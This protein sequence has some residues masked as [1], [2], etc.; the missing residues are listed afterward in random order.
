[1]EAHNRASIEAECDLEGDGG[2]IVDDDDDDIND[3]D[4][5]NNDDADSS[6]DDKAGGKKKNVPIH[7]RH[8]TNIAAELLMDYS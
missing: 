5:D 8:I 1:M 2:G 3:D 7:A 6:F 4:D